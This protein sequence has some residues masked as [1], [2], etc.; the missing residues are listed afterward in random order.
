MAG[1]VQRGRAQEDRP[2][3]QPY[4]FTALYLQRATPRDGGFFNTSK[5]GIVA[6]IPPGLIGTRAWDS[7]AFSDGGYTDG[8]RMWEPDRK[9][10]V[11]IDDIVCVRYPG[12]L[13]C[14]AFLL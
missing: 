4:F 11:Y 1:E 10:N 5:V 6:S 13:P 2:S 12:S 7:A 14:D 8:A 3:H 9:G